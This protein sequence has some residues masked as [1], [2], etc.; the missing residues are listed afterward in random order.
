MVSDIAC[1]HSIHRDARSRGFFGSRRPA[2]TN[3]ERVAGA[4]QP[5]WVNGYIA[6]LTQFG[7]SSHSYDLYQSIS[8]YLNNA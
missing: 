6:E 7:S 8:Y 2:Q 5:G 4:S 1:F 3:L